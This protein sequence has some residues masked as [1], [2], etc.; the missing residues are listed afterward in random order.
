MIFKLKVNA[1]LN[2]IYQFLRH[3]TI[4]AMVVNLDSPNL[5]RIALLAYVYV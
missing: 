4:E 5:V 1:R 3:H 2:L